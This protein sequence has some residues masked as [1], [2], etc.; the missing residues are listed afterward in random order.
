MTDLIPAVPPLVYKWRMIAMR[1]RHGI[2]CGK[3]MRQL[4]FKKA[5]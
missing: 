1:G 4:L 2:R 5:H 3:R